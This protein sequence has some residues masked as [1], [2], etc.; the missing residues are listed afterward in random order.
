MARLAAR[1]RHSNLVILITLRKEIHPGEAYVRG[2]RRNALYRRE[3]DLLQELYWE[4][5]IQRKPLRQ[6][7]NL[8]F[9]EV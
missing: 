9:S 4:A 7:K 8:A 3:R 1:W 5:K 2:S 6:G